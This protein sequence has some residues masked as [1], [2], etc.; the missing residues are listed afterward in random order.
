MTAEVQPGPSARDRF[1][2]VF[3]AEFAYVCTS[4]RRLG[5]S[6]RDIEDVAHDLF[7]E[8]WRRFETY[9]RGRPIRPWLFAFAFR[10]ASDYR[11]LSRHKIELL[12]TKDALEPSALADEML[13]KKDA[14]R[15]LFAA[16]ESIDVE[17]RAVF[18]LFELDECPMQEIA[19]SL[20]I[21]LNTAYSRLR[22]AREE[23]QAAAVRIHKREAR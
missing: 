8:V 18:I 13:A 19:A 17:R 11:R 4:L 21:P 2:A 22:L 7:V 23:F 15:L 5:V 20:S 1:Q 14:Q 3:E 12:V 10:F 6:E 9:D 16:L